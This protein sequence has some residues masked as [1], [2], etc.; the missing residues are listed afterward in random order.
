MT[1]TA[2]DTDAAAP[3]AL[4]DWQEGRHAAAIDRLDRAVR[5]GDE[6]ALTLLVQLSG[7]EPD[8]AGTRERAFAAMEAMAPCMMRNRHRAY[9]QAG[10]PCRHT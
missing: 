5:A 3:T 8:R 9:F 6:A 4:R 10:R 7:H 1:A 2:P